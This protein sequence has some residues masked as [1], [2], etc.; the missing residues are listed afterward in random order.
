[1][2]SYL[3]CNE[4]LSHTSYR[5]RQ[6]DT[7]DFEEVYNSYSRDV[8]RYCLSLCGSQATADDITSDT[9]LKA[10]NKGDTFEGKCSVKVWLFQIAKNTYLDYLRK[11]KKLTD[12]PEDLQYENDF[13][14][15]LLDKAEALKIHKLLHRLNEPYKE[16]FSLRVFSE[17]SFAEIGEIFE[18]TE[19]W[20]RVTY[21]RAKSRIKELC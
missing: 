2:N 11:H 13:E 17:L 4:L 14:I 15:E 12:L 8:Y 21:Y 7:V 19:S 5:Q 3:L 6:V 20:A 10:I 9:F 1:M 18:K 16:I